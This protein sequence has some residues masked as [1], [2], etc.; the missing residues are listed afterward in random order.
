MAI[1]AEDQVLCL[2]Q[3]WQ[4]C[5]M[6]SIKD[7]TEYDSDVAGDGREDAARIMVAAKMTEKEA[8]TFISGLDNSSPLSAIEWDITSEGD[9][10][11]R[12]FYFN[13]LFYGGATEYI[14]GDNPSIVYNDSVYY[15]AIAEDTFTAI[16]PGVTSGWEDYW[17]EY[18]IANLKDQIANTSLDIKIHDDIVTCNFENC[19][20]AS[21]DKIPDNILC[22][23]CVSSE[24][25]DTLLTMDILLDGA[26]SKNWQQKAPQAET[27]L[28]EANKKYCNCGCSTPK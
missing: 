21:L 24:Q 26:N 3:R 5:S 6:F 11:Y 7:E 22:G 19:I 13:I 18:D 16:E 23:L 4:D 15:I 25:L 17:E 12:F 2:P 10:A 20:L 27:I 28:R 9:G 1:L 8:L 14:G